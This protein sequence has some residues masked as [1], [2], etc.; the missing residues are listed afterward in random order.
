[1]KSVDPDRILT[2]R[3]RWLSMI[4][5]FA[6]YEIQTKMW[7]DTNN[8]NPHWT[9]AELMC[10]YFEDLGFS[11]DASSLDE[12]LQEGYISENE[13]SAAELFHKSAFLYKPPNND[14]YDHK[15]ILTDAKW[16]AIVNEAK[17][18]KNKLRQLLSIRSELTALDYYDDLLGQL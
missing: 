6:L 4:S 8:P 9:F 2:W 7:L 3:K 13:L 17:N 10:S 16:I 1:M 11:D 14:H 15:R 18:V 12:L 5:Y